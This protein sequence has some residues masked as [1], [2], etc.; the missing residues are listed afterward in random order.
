MLIQPRIR[1]G[2]T[3]FL[4]NTGDREEA[5]DAVLLQQILNPDDIVGKGSQFIP[6]RE[7]LQGLEHTGSEDL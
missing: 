6:G 4:G 3:H 1:L 5:G 7:N 2:I